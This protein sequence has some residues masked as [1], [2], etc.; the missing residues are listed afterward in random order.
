MS[1]P[2]AA[3]I[4]AALT[5]A[6]CAPSTPD[7]DLVAEE[8]PADGDAAL[9][10]S[11][12]AGSTLIATTDVNLRSGPS[13][14]DQIL[15]VVPAGAT[16]TVLA[17]DPNNGFYNVK[18]NGVA[19]FSYGAYY[20]VGQ[21]APDNPPPPSDP[22]ATDVT[23]DQLLAI[24]QSCSQLPG[25]T[26]FRADS[27]ASKTIPVCSL[28]GA[29]WWRGDMDIDC[30]G[31]KGA[32]CKSDPYYQSDTAA[33]DSKGNPLDASTL[34]YVV[35]PGPSNGFDYKANGLKLGSVVAVIY[36]G[37]MVYGILGDIGPAG[38]IGEASYA[39]AVQ[40]GINGSPISG[41]VDSGVTYIAFTGSSAVVT[42]KEDHAQAEAL[43]KTAA[44]KLVQSN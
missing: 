22:G 28:A 24:T 31:G 13:T 36:K 40:L 1:L 20:K 5:L 15:H 44:Q 17:A 27:G 3:W 16:V 42:K 38:V 33:T 9:S 23:P 10:G 41:G 29:V 6:A 12:P 30:D 18:H 37:K 26:K 35:I 4:A 25:T 8:A 2:R 39:L 34:P 14:S 32:T 7:T 43:G 11:I 21:L 19:G